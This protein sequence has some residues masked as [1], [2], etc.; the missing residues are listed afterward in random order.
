MLNVVKVLSS[1]TL[2]EE[3]KKEVSEIMVLSEEK[4]RE[5]LLQVLHSISCDIKTVIPVIKYFYY[6]DLLSEISKQNWVSISQMET[7]YEM[8]DCIDDILGMKKTH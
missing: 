3:E 5:L 6:Y 7:I 8:Q 2:S 1:L 4:K